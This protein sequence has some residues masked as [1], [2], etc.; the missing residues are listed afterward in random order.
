M[1]KQPNKLGLRAKIKDYM[2]D[3]NIDVFGYENK[4][5]TNISKY[6]FDLSKESKISAEGINI[7]IAYPIHALEAHIYH[8]DRKIRSTSIKELTVFFIGQESTRVLDLET[9]VQKNVLNYISQ[10]SRKSNIPIY[11]LSIRVSKPLNEV[12]IVM[13]KHSEIIESIPL[14]ELIKY[15]K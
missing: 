12:N 14:K 15:F 3:V 8:F 13:Y 10:Y 11:C 4:V 2:V 5:T 1:K 6:L 7:R 9:K